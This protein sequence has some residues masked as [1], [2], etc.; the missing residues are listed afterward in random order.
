MQQNLDR[1]QCR[2]FNQL[3]KKL[4][5]GYG[6]RIVDNMVILFDK[7]GRE[8]NVDRGH[9]MLQ[10]LHFSTGLKDKNGKLIFEGDILETKDK[11]IFTVQYG[12]HDTNGKNGQPSCSYGF[13]LQSHHKGYITDCY[14]LHQIDG[15]CCY[16]PPYVIE[17]PIYASEV[18]GVEIIG[19][20]Y[21]QPQ[22]L[23]K[24]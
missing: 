7:N 4:V 2:A 12:L 13:Y 3:T 19:N 18:L 20:I 9:C 22:L 1:M 6:Y 17:N 21:E 24:Q 5:Y 10:D 15:V 11:K 8:V 16:M 23:E 14:N